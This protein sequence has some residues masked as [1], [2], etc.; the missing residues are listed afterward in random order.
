MLIFTHSSLS[1]SL[2]QDVGYIFG[3]SINRS[4]NGIACD[5]LIDEKSLKV[6]NDFV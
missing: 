5:Y 4:G 6:I 1:Q 2:G 3:E